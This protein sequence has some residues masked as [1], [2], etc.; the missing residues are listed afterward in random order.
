VALLRAGGA[1]A[2][3]AL[4]LD[5]LGDALVDLGELEEAKAQ[6]LEGTAVLGSEDGLD[7]DT[8]TAA[9][10]VNGL[11]DVQRLL[12]AFEAADAAYQHVL[13]LF[14]RL[15]DPWGLARAYNNLGI[16]AGTRG[17]YPAA[18]GYF[19]QGLARFRELGDRSGTARCLHNLST[20]AFLRQ[21]YAHCRDLRLACL[22]ICR[23]IGF[24]WGVVSTLKHL[25]D[26][27]KALGELAAA[28]GHYEESLAASERVLDPRS[29]ALTLC[30]LADL[31]AREGQH[32]RAWEAYQRALGLA[33]ETEMLP[34][35]IDVL[36][37]MAE[38]LAAAGGVGAAVALLGLVEGQ[39]AVDQQ[40]RDRAAAVLAGLAAQLPAAELS[41]H[42]ARG[43][44]LALEDVSARLR[45]MALHRFLILLQLFEGDGQAV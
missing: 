11:G 5:F 18:A 1:P 22:D 34:V 37:G 24:Q 29:T 7:F 39:T 32:G 2:R 10:L 19:E 12:G 16:L 23:E 21:D 31:S 13:R 17:D 9:L 14:T 26:V 38:L 42:H 28:R 40:T 33:V 25:A 41:A 35:A 36:V 4:A 8:M 3:L 30:G 45:G 15:A 27:E 43:R 20:L 44:Q 6:Y